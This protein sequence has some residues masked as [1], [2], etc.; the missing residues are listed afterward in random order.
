M[1]EEQTIPVSLSLDQLKAFATVLT[2]GSLLQ[3]ATLRVVAECEQ[4]AIMA[5]QMRCAR[6]RQWD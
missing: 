2:Q 5:N 6:Q 1:G 4:K 3:E